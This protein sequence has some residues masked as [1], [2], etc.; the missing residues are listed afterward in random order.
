MTFIGSRFVL[1]Y[2]T[3][4][5]FNF[6]QQNKPNVLLIAHC[7]DRTRETE[8]EGL[9]GHTLH[10]LNKLGQQIDDL[11][12]IV[13]VVHDGSETEDVTCKLSLYIAS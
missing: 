6:F 10:M 12:V 11:F 7:V 3:N 9:V 8:D 4:I 2:C 13:V 5:I 1:F